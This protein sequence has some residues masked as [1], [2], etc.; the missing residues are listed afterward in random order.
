MKPAHH[1]V[2]GKA[3][4]AGL[5]HKRLRRRNGL[6]AGGF[7]VEAGLALSVGAEQPVV[8]GAGTEHGAQSPAHQVGRK[9]GLPRP[10]R[11]AILVQHANEFERQIAHVR[12]IAERIG[13]ANEAG[14]RD[15]QMVESCCI[16]RPRGRLWNMQIEWWP[17]RHDSP[18]R[19]SGWGS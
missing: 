14:S 9:F 4:V 19:W 6:L 2:G 8:E 3:H 17:V 1:P 13:T 16:P 18:S 5:E 10:H 7:H 11:L 15:I 12:S